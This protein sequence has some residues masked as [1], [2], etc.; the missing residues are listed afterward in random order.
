MTLSGAMPALRYR[1]FR[2]FFAGQSLSLL[3]TWMQTVANSWLVY[4]LTGSATLLG[5]TAAAQQLPFLLVS[6]LAG[7]MA[8][9]SN[10]QRLLLIT[11][12]VA[13]AQVL[14]LAALTF[15]HTVHTAAYGCKE[16]HTKTFPYKAVV[17]KASMADMDAGKSCGTCH[18]GKDVFAIGG[19]GIGTHLLVNSPSG[20]LADTN[21]AL[22]DRAASICPVGVILPKRRGF[23]IPIGERQYDRSSVAAQVEQ[24]TEA[25]K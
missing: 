1:N 15:S 23:S 11:Q 16:C 4:R 22:T 5:I 17:G 8:E 9:R 10:R 20:K 6:P 12:V 21:M 18:N 7:V 24:G 25:A 3:G 2:I 13:L 19:H 14:T